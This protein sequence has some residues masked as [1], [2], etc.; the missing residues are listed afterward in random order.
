MDLPKIKY[1]SDTV[2]HN[3]VHRRLCMYVDVIRNR[4]DTSTYIR[5]RVQSQRPRMEGVLW[6]IAYAVRLFRSDGHERL[7]GT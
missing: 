7:I 1:V 3:R 6:K 4:A 2:R 5:T